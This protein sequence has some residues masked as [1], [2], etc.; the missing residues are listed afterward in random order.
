MLHRFA[1]VSLALIMTAC[2][3]APTV[4]QPGFYRPR[5]ADQQMQI[6]GSLSAPDVFKVG[7]TVTIN[8]DGTRAASGDSEASFSGTWQGRKVDADCSHTGGPWTGLTAATLSLVGA[9]R[10]GVK[11]LVFVDGERAASLTL[12]R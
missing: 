2:A 6:T 8:I 3:G 5:G 11:C 12:L 10:P 9:D 1:V 7:R 4:S